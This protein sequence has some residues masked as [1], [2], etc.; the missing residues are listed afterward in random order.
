MPA[1]L[2]LSLS[3]RFVEL[4]EIAAWASWV[5]L[6]PCSGTGT[7][8]LTALL[9]SFALSTRFLELPRSVALLLLFVELPGLLLEFSVGKFPKFDFVRIAILARLGPL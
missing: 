7:I 3:T 9:S 1:L 6:A 8:S 2:D 5:G 4:I